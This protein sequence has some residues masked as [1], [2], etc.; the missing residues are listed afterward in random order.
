MSRNNKVQKESLLSLIWSFDLKEAN[1]L[2][3]SVGDTSYIK[4]YPICFG[5]H[6][7]IF[8]GESETVINAL[9]R[10]DVSLSSIKDLVKYKAIL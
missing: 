4:G 10:D 2:F 3:R 1:Q 5:I 6:Q 8:E 9:P 7:F